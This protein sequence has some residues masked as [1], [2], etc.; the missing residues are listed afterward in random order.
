MKGKLI[1]ALVVL[2]LV[3]GVVLVSCDNGNRPAPDWKDTYK[4]N[5]A[6]VTIDS[7]DVKDYDGFGF[8]LNN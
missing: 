7:H 1:T 3:F 6:G 8:S 2:A 5:S 4:K